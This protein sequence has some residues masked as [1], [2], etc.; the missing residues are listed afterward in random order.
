MGSQSMQSKL[1]G[2]RPNDWATLQ[3]PTG[4]SGY[5]YALEFLQPKQSD[6]MLDIGCG[7]GLFATLAAKLCADVTGFDATEQL[8]K[9]AK[10]R[11]PSVYFLTGEMEELPFDDNIFDIVSGFNSFQYAA[12]VKHALSEATRVLK[13]KG[14]LVVMIWGDKEDCEALTYLKAVGSLLP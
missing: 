11:N 4:N 10:L 9:E 5:E 14:K 8:I 6:K 12:D 1:W 2:Q 13:D 3:E 7:S